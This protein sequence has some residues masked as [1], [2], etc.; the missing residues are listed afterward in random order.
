MSQTLIGDRTH[1]DKLRLQAQWAVL[2]D[3]T[4]EGAL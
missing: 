4:L 1:V 2:S 3:E